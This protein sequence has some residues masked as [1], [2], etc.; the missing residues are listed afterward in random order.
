M[1]LLDGKVAIV[2]GGGT[3]IGEAISK[4]FALEGARVVVSG[5]PDDPVDDVAQGIREDGGTAIAVRGD[6]SEPD[7][8]KACVERAI[9]EFGRL[10]V[11]VNNAGVFQVTGEHQDIGVEDYDFMTKNNVR[12]ALLM[13]KF[14]LPHLQESRGNIVFTGSEAGTI[15]QPRCAIYGGTKGY[16]IAFARGIALE[17]ASHGVRA[18]VVC[19]GPTKTEWHDTDSSSMQED[20]EDQ[21]VKSVP[22]GRHGDPEEIANVFAFVASDRA[23]FVTGALYFSDGGIQISRGTPGQQVPDA[24]R[25][26]PE[27]RVTLRH[28]MQGMENVDTHEA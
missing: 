7:E 2:T 6:V 15:G 18:N 26:P 9:D 8:A 14:A 28:Q 24:L 17:Q 11:L 21:I 16:L 13:T 10:D 22:M 23:S 12:S 20:M 25:E 1:G 3:G 27:G 19:P 5:L 4:V